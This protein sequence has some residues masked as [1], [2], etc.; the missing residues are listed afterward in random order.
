MAC[1]DGV[2]YIKTMLSLQLL[3]VHSRRGGEV[4][5]DGESP[6]RQYHIGPCADFNAVIFGGLPEGEELET[7]PVCDMG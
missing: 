1:A 2:N 6:F 7:W 4:F 3:Y 5:V